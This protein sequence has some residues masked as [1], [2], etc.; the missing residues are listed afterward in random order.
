MMTT[1]T[2]S[3]PRTPVVWLVIGMLAVPCLANRGFSE[4]EAANDD[5]GPLGRGLL[6]SPL[7]GDGLGLRNMFKRPLLRRTSVPGDRVKWIRYPSQNEESNARWGDFLTDV[8]RHLPTQ[9]GRRYYSDDRITHAH[10]T[11]HGINSHLSNHPDEIASGTRPRGPGYGFYVGKD[12]AVIL[13]GPRLK[14][15]QVAEVIPASLRGSRYQLYCIEQQKYFE[16]RPLY[17][18]DEWV[19]YTNGASAGVELTEKK[20]LDMP[21]NDALVAPLEF[22]IYSLGL[23]AAIQKH[24]PDYLR[25]NPQFREFLAHELRRATAIYRRGMKLDQF[26]W[27]QKLGENLLAQDDSRELRE[28]VPQLFGEDLTLQE[29]IGESRVTSGE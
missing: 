1:R 23:A 24:D 17:L 19:A 9:Y 6:P 8:A 2:L 27:E 21:R 26:R 22:S 10:E 4:E 15:S 12:Q 25:Q 28:I 13:F 20:Q 5:G 3:V 16:D 18:F 7:R 14:L 29:L 11:T